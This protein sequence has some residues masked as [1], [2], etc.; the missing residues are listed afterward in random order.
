MLDARV[1][2]V[3]LSGVMYHESAGAE[4]QRL[5][6]A[7]IPM[8]SLAGIRLPSVPLVVCDH[9]QGMAD[10]TGHLLSLGYRKL[11]LVSAMSATDR[12]EE[13]N[14]VLQERLQGFRQA[15]ARAGLGESE[16]KVLWQPMR[17]ESF[18]SYEPGRAAVQRLIENPARPDALLCSNDDYAIGAVG[19]C[20]EAGLRVPEDLAITGFDNTTVGRYIFPPL[21]TVAQPTEAMAQK[22]VALLLKLI[23]GEKILAGEDLVKL[24]CEV[25]VRQSCGTKKLSVTSKQ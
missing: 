20:A 12:D 2:G 7:K 22:A 19:L 14:W 21:T 3:L 10:L 18:D 16:A 13:K 8:V 11:A 24:P 9:R 4:L 17:S 6:D 25:V 23:R 1:E 5:C 15:T